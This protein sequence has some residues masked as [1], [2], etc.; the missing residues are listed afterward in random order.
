MKKANPAH[1][2]RVIERNRPYDTFGWGVVFSDAT[3]EN[4]RAADTKTHDEIVD[5][6]AHWDDIEIHFKGHAMRSGGH[7]FSG[8]ARKRLLNILQRRAEEVGVQLEFEREV[9]D[10]DAYAEADLIIASD[11]ANSRIRG[12]HAQQF[13][14]NLDTRK[15][16]FVWLGTALPLDAFTF[17]F[18]E[19]PHG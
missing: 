8:I 6:F 17:V 14:P 11:G 19:T 12:A 2:I 15:C 18:E 5:S 4:L 16:R 7:G 10:L 13:Q 3:L 1:R 9:A